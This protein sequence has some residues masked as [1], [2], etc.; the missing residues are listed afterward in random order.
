MSDIIKKAKAGAKKNDPHGRKGPA[1]QDGADKPASEDAISL[2]SVINKNR[3]AGEPVRNEAPDP[4]AEAADGKAAAA[5]DELIS[6]SKQIYESYLS[7]M[8]ALKPDIFTTVETVVDLM[9]TGSVKMF[10]SVFRDYSGERDYLYVHC[11]NVSVMS[12]GLAIGLAF[13]RTS[14]VELGV[15]A[16]LHDIGAIECS[17][18][19]YSEEKLKKK[20]LARMRKHPERGAEILRASGMDINDKVIEAVLQEHERLD[21]SGYPSGLGKKDISEYARVIAVADVYEAIIHKRPYRGTMTT[22]EAIKSM[23]ENKKMFERE[24][25]RSLLEKV[26]IFPAGTCVQLNNRE[27]AMVVSNNPKAPFSPVVDIVIDAEGNKL[28]TPRR[29]DLRGNNAIYIRDCL[30]VK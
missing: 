20:E 25:L 16:L 22:I 29:V 11:A 18:I 28:D 23:L 1:P 21:G 27:V 2:S 26:G 30:S 14:L 10:E 19:I 3:V 4:D 8:L 5:Y 7:A 17:D 13:D 15:A 6:K 12:V 24:V 9:K